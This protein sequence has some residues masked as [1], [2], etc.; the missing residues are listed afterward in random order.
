MV[1]KGMDSRLDHYEAAHS[2][3]SNQDQSIT[4]AD[5]LE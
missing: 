4:I 5:M 2:T 3:A 1:S